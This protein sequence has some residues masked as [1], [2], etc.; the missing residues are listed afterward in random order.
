M[1]KRILALLCLSMLCSILLSGCRCKPE[2]I[3]WYAR[4]FQKTE[5]FVN[6]AT[7]TVTH[8]G[9]PSARDPFGGMDSGFVGIS[10]SEDGTVVFQPGTGEVLT[11]T[12]TYEDS[13]RSTDIAVTLSN[14]ESFTC[15]ARSNSY[16]SSL[17]LSFRGSDYLFEDIRTAPET[18]YQD[19]LKQLCD[20][21][22]YWTEN[23]NGDIPVKPCNIFTRN[24]VYILESESLN[25]PVKL[26]ETVA[27]RCFR[28]DENN[29][30]HPMNA[31]VE[32]ECFFSGETFNEVTYVTIYYV[33]PVSA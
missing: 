23:S 20:T 9:T 31:I 22:G 24:G 14:G 25:Q 1:K 32:G 27:V 2:K 29:Q 15:T 6:G 19:N 16:G 30:L 3:T 5:V 4:S 12:Y 13:R 7:F 21:I 10:F 28:L 17:T 18:Y 11:G 33:D 26:D 8:T